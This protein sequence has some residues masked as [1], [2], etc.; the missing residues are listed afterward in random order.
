MKNIVPVVLSGGAGTR[1]WPQSR[2]SMPKQFVNLIGD[3][4]LFEATFDRMTD[5]NLLPGI[6]VANEEQ[7]FIVAE[8]LR[9]TGNVAFRL[10]L[11]PCGRNTAP[12]IAVA[13]LQALAENP[14]AI[15]FVA[16]ADHLLEVNKELQS[17]LVQA[18]EL[19]AK[20]KIVTFGVTPSSPNTGYGYIK[21]DPAKNNSVVEFVEKP[22]LESAI[23][24]VKNG[25]YLWNS[26]MFM[27]A[28]GVYLDELKRLAPAVFEACNA[29]WQ[30]RTQD[31]LFTRLGAEEFFRCPSDSIDFAIMEK[32][33]QAAVVRLDCAWS[34]L[35]SWEGVWEA[36]ER[37]DDDNATSGRAELV[38]S[39]GN[40]VRSEGRLI[41]LI[42]CKNL[43]VIDSGDAI[44]VADRESSQ[45][46]KDMVNRLKRK[47]HSEATTHARVYRPW[48]NYEGIDLGDRY[49][50]KRIVVQPGEILSLQKHHHRA[51]HW[52]VVRGVALVT[53]DEDQ[54]LVNENESTYIP[55]G[56][57]HRMENPGKIPLELIEVQS[58]SYLGEDDIIRIED[59]YGRRAGDRVGSDSVEAIQ[60][61]SDRKKVA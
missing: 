14:D 9:T 37:D 13:A 58:G 42:G 57:V 50:V 53:C 22:D 32:T 38:N 55:L 2:E 41:S 40:L 45:T 10:L 31:S 39:T 7:R 20:R 11:E 1:L 18:A 4:S 3:K 12:A 48:G 43:V 49:Q 61:V 52:I 5:M 17:A 33:E 60:S 16:P 46:V 6:V 34:D 35:G 56:S 54:K 47:G 24:Y 15:L 30:A 59:K 27:C 36:S 19:A 29:A 26:G 25:S 8:Q 21:T 51:E 23:K 44:L 28:A